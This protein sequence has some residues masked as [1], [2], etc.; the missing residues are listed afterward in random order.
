MLKR[1]EKNTEKKLEKKYWKKTFYTFSRRSVPLEDKAGM[2]STV[3]KAC[4]ML[5]KNFK[6]KVLI[7]FRFENLRMACVVQPSG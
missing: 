5:V 4:S 3:L 2:L 7:F 6:F 1:L